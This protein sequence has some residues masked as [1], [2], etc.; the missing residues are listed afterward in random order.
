VLLGNDV[1]DAHLAELAG[2]G[3]SYIVA[4]TADIDLA[5]ALDTLASH[6]PI[7]RLLLEGGGGI[8]GSMIAA[9][10]VDELQVLIVPALDGGEGVQS[11]VSYGSQGLAGSVKLAFRAAT[12]MEHGTV[13]LTYDVRPG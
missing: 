4:D 3:V 9:G 2:H 5:A 13:L 7:R 10:L 11:I 1:P 8:N 12:P 6:F